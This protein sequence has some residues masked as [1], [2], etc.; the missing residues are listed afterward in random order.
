[1]P[2]YRRLTPAHACRILLLAAV[3]LAPLPSTPASAAK[4]ILC[5]ATAPVV[6]GKPAKPLVPDPDQAIEIRADEVSAVAGT[7]AEFSGQVELTRGA[8]HLTADRLAYDKTTDIAQ[9]LGAVILENDAG[10]RFETSEISLNLHTR[11]GHTG[12][13]T[14]LLGQK[15]GRGDAS[16]IDF[17]GP[18]LT[19]LRDVRYTTC[20]PG[21]DDWFLHVRELELDT[22]E[23]IGTARH[24]WLDFK[25]VPI[26]Y[27]PYISF[28]ISDQRKSG[29]LVPRLGYSSQSGYQVAT[30]YYFN[31]A[32]EYDDTFT[33]RLLTKR[34]LQFTNQFRYLG[35]RSSGRLELEALPQDKK[36]GDD[37][38]AGNF[39]HQNSF[40][41]LWSASVD[42][43]AVSDKD[44]LNDFADHI[45]ITSQTHLPQNAEINYRGP[46]WAFTARAADYQTVDPTIAPADRPYARLPQFMLSTN[47]SGRINTP[48]YHF[49]SEWVRFERGGRLNGDRASLSP[50]VSLPLTT[51]A[52]GFL[53]PRLGARYI[54]YDLA[55]SENSQDTTPALARGIF[56]LDSGL[57]FERDTGWFG[58]D[59]IQTLEPRLYY[60]FIP[61]TNQD[62]LPNFDTSVP[63]FS[64]TNLFRDNRFVGGDRIG[65]ANQLTTAVTSRYLDADDG[66]ERF[67]V[68]LGL[69]QYFNDRL[70]NLPAGTITRSQSDTVAEAAARLASNW[71]AQGGVQWNQDEGSA[72]KR[73]V[74]L[75]YNPEKNKIVNLGHRYIRNEI[76][77]TDVS[78][79]WLLAGRWSLRARSLYSE[80]DHHNVESY[81]GLDYNTC[82]WALRAFL[83]RRFSEGVGQVHAIL[84]EFELSGLSKRGSAPA[85]PLEQSLFFPRDPARPTLR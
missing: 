28:P 19:H 61:Y 1:M 82:C 33:P 65:D 45:G 63:D 54:G 68:S 29:F 64:F 71:Y 7:S 34:G 11:V 26:F 21:Q 41:P 9:A 78:T 66:A 36:F 8:Q 49:D 83:S 17:A 81:V 14:Y 12:P 24:A 84:F 39:I 37:R 50:A 16:R 48:Q 76:E 74:Y 75:Q 3:M 56:S 62:T 44:Y 59:Y 51:A 58:R 6:G 42:V 77:Q 18:T 4:R 53:T 5:P 35:P 40:T 22:D 60:L 15:Y 32:P 69:I 79:E 27:W 52:Y 46:G 47:P 23:D 67:R 25:G 57:F 73:N 85:S 30:P 2:F 10:D 20:A 43:R 72:E 31:L 55:R 70:V 80:R 13:S 38:A